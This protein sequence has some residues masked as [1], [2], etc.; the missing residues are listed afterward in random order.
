MVNVALAINWNE[1][2]VYYILNHVFLCFG[3]ILI[4][5]NNRNL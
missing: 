4:N 1:V 2:K 3:S 5:Y